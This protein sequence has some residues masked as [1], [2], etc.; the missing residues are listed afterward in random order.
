MTA[1]KVI[2]SPVEIILGQ[3]DLPFVI[4]DS[5][6]L[7]IE[8]RQLLKCAKNDYFKRK[9]SRIYGNLC[10]P[11]KKYQTFS[12]DKRKEKNKRLISYNLAHSPEVS[13]THYFM[14]LTQAKL[15]KD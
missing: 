15:I 6:F 5:L 1:P 3:K 4:K 11:Q 2:D 8:I 13:I 12:A 9:Q 14:R 10:S 7:K